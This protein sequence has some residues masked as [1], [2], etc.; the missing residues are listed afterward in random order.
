MPHGG[1][2]NRLSPGV[3]S[4]DRPVAADFTVNGSLISRSEFFVK[5]VRKS[6][7]R[8]DSDV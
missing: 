4:A 1:P 3:F 8:K 2:E 5:G 7:I 6:L